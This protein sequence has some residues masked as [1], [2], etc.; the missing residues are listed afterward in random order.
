M[1][2]VLVE[3]FLGYPCLLIG[4]MVEI[5]TASPDYLGGALRARGTGCA[6]VPIVV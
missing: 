6:L 3:R 4:K 2:N 5:S 1:A